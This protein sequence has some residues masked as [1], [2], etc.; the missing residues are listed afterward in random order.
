MKS[1]DPHKEESVNPSTS[2]SHSECTVCYH[3][4][5]SQNILSQLASHRETQS[6]S[7]MFITVHQ[8][9]LCAAYWR[10]GAALNWSQVTWKIDRDYEANEWKLK[11]TVN[12]I[13]RVRRT[14]LIND[15]NP[16]HVLR[17]QTSCGDPH[18]HSRLPSRFFIFP[19]MHGPR[20]HVRTVQSSFHTQP[21]QF[22]SKKDSVL[23]F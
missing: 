20:L 18:K 22:R 17:P 11:R 16:A 13:S 3:G 21:A 7:H 6:L 1:T 10:A 12:I 4:K 9:R 5:K 8:K 14:R 19:F 2:L 23:G 15:L